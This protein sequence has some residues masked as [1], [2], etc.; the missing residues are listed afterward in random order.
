MLFHV[1]LRHNAD[2]CPGFNPDLMQ[3]TME[4]LPKLD[5]VAGRYSI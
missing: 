3:R 1:T 4:M 5:E 2:N